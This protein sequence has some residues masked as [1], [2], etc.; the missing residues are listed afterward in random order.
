[1]TQ[2]TAPAQ[3]TRPSRLPSLVLFLKA[4]ELDTRMLGMI[5]RAFE[6]ACVLTELAGDPRNL[7]VKAPRPCLAELVARLFEDGQGGVGHEDSIFCPA[8]RLS[9]NAQ[10]LALDARLFDEI[11]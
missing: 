3:R 1:M 10:E 7:A 8:C 6:L 9:L 4:T 5:E 11:A 2:A